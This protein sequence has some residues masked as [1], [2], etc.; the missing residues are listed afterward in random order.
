VCVRVCVCVC[1]WGT[2]PLCSSCRLGTAQKL[3]STVAQVAAVLGTVDQDLPLKWAARVCDSGN[4][5]SPR[6]G[7]RLSQ[8]AQHGVG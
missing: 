4:I 6:G 7:G 1:M 5:G 2:V 8:H 3:G